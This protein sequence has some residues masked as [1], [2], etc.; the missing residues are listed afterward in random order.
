M[1]KKDKGGAGGD[2]KEKSNLVPAI[3]VAIGAVLG[4]KFAAGGG[5]ASSSSAAPTTTA[6]SPESAGE[7][8]STETTA[9]QGPSDTAATG[10][11]AAPADSA[12]QS[13]S[14]APIT[15][16]P[17]TTRAKPTTTTGSK[18]AAASTTT[19]KASTI[20]WTYDGDQGPVHWAKLS[21][22][23]AACSD[24]KAQSPIDLK[25]AQA[26]NLPDVG[27]AFTSAEVKIRNNGHFIAATVPAGST[28][29]LFGKQFDLVELDL[30]TPSEHL[31]DGKSSPMELQFVTKDADGQ[32]AVVAVLVD[33]GDVN[34]KLSP[35]LNAI[36]KVAGESGDSQGPLELGLLL[37]DDKTA[38]RYDGS[39]TS[40]PCT[41]GVK[42][43]VLET[44]LKASKQQ[45]GKLTAVLDKNNRPVQDRHD[46]AVVMDAADG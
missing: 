11:G 1:A 19:T 34:E 39:L 13:P 38:F 28:L 27:V 10:E 41:E 3:V 23:F 2:G 9:A 30:H 25:D 35:L 45:I 33:R 40:P 26:L 18:P 20:T 44:H 32:R 16:A 12:P 6:A 46:R 29:T 4:A 36:P 31:V 37:P 15:A 8:A 14:S 22:A 21:P 5:S 24:G 17:A 7:G 43:I 42:W